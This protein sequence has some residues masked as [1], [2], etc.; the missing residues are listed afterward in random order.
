[1]SFTPY[2]LTLATLAA[3]LLEPSGIDVAIDNK[4][5][6]GETTSQM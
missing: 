3:D 5:V 2:T 6:S 1:M 4:G